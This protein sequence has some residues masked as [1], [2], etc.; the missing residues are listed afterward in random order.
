MAKVVDR[1]PRLEESKQTIVTLGSP[2]RCLLGLPDVWSPQLSDKFSRSM[3]GVGS[4]SADNAPL[5]R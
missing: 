2:S 1:V 4:P 3:F 5:M